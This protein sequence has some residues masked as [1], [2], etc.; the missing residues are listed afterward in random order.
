MDVNRNAGH[1][2]GVTG[3]KT[4]CS[5]CSSVLRA[6]RFSEPE[7]RMSGLLTGPVRN[8]S[9]LHP[10]PTL[11][12]LSLGMRGTQSTDP[13]KGLPGLATGHCTRRCAG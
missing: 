1:R 12:L 4:S 9:G 8:L 3:C 11:V 5:T 6:C 2:V 7:T 10:S 13:S